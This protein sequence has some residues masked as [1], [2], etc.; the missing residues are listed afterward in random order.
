M[1]ITFLTIIA[2]CNF[3]QQ[4]KKYIKDQMSNTIFEI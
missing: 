4:I 1:F 2:S 3:V